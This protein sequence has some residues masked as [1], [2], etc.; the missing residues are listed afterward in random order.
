M[1]EIKTIVYVGRIV[2]VSFEAH[3]SLENVYQIPVYQIQAQEHQRYQDAIR[4][5]IGE[6]SLRVVLGSPRVI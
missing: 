2:C 6:H 4:F 1:N 3:F 5:C